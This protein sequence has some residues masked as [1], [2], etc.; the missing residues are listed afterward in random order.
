MEAILD[1]LEG[2][3]R[4]ISAVV[5]F[6][7]DLVEGLLYAVE[8]MGQFVAEIPNYFNWLPESVVAILVTIFAVV[9]VYKMIG[10]EG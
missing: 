6:V 3:G 4:F 8:L 2:I 1:V 9:V 7:I 5:D 10:R